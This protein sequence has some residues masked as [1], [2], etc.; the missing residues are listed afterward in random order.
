MSRYANFKIL[1]VTCLLLGIVF[2]VKSG[3][4]AQTH[5]GLRAGAT[6]VEV[7]S[8]ALRASAPIQLLPPIDPCLKKGFTDWQDLCVHGAGTTSHDQFIGYR[9]VIYRAKYQ[10][11]LQGIKRDGSVES[12]YQ[13]PV[14]LGTYDSETPLGRFLINHVYC[15]PDLLYYTEDNRIVPAVYDGF[16][17]PLI[18]CDDEGN[19]GRYRGI[20]LHGF[21]AAAYPD[22]GAVAESEGPVSAGC[23]R[24][25]NPCSFKSQLIRRVGV[26]PVKKNDRG[27]Y[28]WLKRPVEVWIFEDEDF[29]ILS[30]LQSGLRG[31]MQ[32][33]SPPDYEN[34]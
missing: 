9:I 29:T 6:A 14:G 8:K 5:P 26:G 2:H 4:T 32:I 10:L 16:L 28:H 34:E 18:A 33:F 23:I 3:E 17:A 12:V 22:P 25:P 30:I 7:G 27:S 1:A 13:T 20:G 21:N 31:F 15:Y 24:V 19:C 11:T